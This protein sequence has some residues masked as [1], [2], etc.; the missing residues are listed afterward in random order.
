MLVGYQDI[1]AMEKTTP[2]KRPYH[3]AAIPPIHK[4]IM[5]FASI[6]N[7]RTGQAPSHSRR[8]TLPGQ[9]QPTDMKRDAEVKL[10]ASQLPRYLYL[11]HNLRSLTIIS[12]GNNLFKQAFACEHVP[13]NGKLRHLRELKVE[14]V[15][16][17]TLAD[18]MALVT[19]PE[20]EQK[21]D[22]YQFS[23]TLSHIDPYPKQTNRQCFAYS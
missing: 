22:T 11:L 2:T 21:E 23:L 19:I 4:L 9:E 1:K 20:E 18:I 14:Q 15:T 3:S 16:L 6:L 5:N 8:I 10:Y 13:D 7:R 17:E 12:D